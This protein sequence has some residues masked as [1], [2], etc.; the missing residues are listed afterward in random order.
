MINNPAQYDIDVY[1][2]RDFSISFII[3]DESEIP[4]D[5][6]DWTCSSQIRPTYNSETLIAD[7]DISIDT[8]LSRITLTL[9]DT[10][11]LGINAENP[12][13]PG[14]TTTSTSMVWDLVAD[15]T[16]PPSER[17][18]VITGIVNFHETVSRASA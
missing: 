11:T 6:S 4:V 7:F 9:S 10:T 5:I 18:T 3:K 15:T 17:F 16:G 8:E 12:I 14:S 1:Q 2:D 13:N